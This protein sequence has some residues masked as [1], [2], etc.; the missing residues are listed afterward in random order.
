MSSIPMNYA[1]NVSVWHLSQFNNNSKKCAYI[2]SCHKIR[3]AQQTQSADIDVRGCV[4]FKENSTHKK[5]R[6]NNNDDN[7]K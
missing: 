5:R 2:Q 3:K 4:F 6:N 7:K 1:N